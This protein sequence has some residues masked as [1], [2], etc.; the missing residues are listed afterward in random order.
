MKKSALNKTHNQGFTLIEVIVAITLFTMV[1]GAVFYF[2][3]NYMNNQAKLKER[4]AVM[5]ISRDFIDAFISDPANIDS[6]GGTEEIEGF[7]LDYQLY[8]AG[9]KEEVLLT[10]GR[11]PMAQLKVVH[12]QVI[13]K[14]TGKNLLDLHFLYNTIS[15]KRR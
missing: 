8:P 2:Y 5:R 7:I 4:Y 10:S 12:L 9:K 14:N 1:I 11:P 3:S 13:Q 6:P 15:R